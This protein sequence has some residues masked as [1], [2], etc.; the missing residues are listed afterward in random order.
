MGE[1]F[2]GES[3]H[4]YIWKNP[5][6]AH[7]KLSQHCLLIG[8]TTVQNKKVFKK[9]NPIIPS[10]LISVPV[11]VCVVSHSAVSDSVP[12]STVACQSPLS[13][14]FSSKNTGAGYHFI[15]QGIFLTQGLNLNLLH[16]LHWQANSLQLVPPGKP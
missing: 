7:L 11:C 6:T 4:V 16:L 15:L 5:F 8:Y 13:K 1:E 3:I 14:E 10:K 12:P 2:G 9:K